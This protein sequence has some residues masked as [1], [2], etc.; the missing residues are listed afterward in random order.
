MCGLLLVLALLL[1]K[2]DSQVLEINHLLKYI[3]C[4]P[5]TQELLV[6]FKYVH[7]SFLTVNT[8]LLEQKRER[9]YT[10]KGKKQRFSI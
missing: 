8:D 10:H 5:K 7:D 6:V 9:S 1:L 2:T 3:Q 4:K